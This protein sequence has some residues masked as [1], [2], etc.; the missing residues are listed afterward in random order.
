[1]HSRSPS[2]GA[3]FS[4]VR[5]LIIGNMVWG[6][7]SSPAS[8]PSLFHVHHGGSHNT[9]RHARREIPRGLGT[10]SDLSDINPETGLIDPN[11]LRHSTWMLNRMRTNGDLVPH[12]PKP[13]KPKMPSIRFVPHQDSARPSLQFDPISRTLPNTTDVIRVGRYSEKDG[14]SYVVSDARSSAPVGFKSKVVS[15]KHCEFWFQ[16]GQWYIKDVKSSSGTFLNRLRLSPASTESRPYQVNDGDIIQ[17][18][19]DFKGGEE[20][21]FR[22][23]K[24]RIECNRDW[25]KSVNPYKYVLP[26]TIQGDLQRTDLKLNPAYVPFD[27][28]RIFR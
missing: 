24:M 2:S 18:G 5:I 26:R 28:C 22:C 1:M 14:Q 23:V 13:A 7:E 8:V 20:M 27:A 15:R 9:S 21:I 12:T 3:S 10:G 16:N 17:L 11:S 25:Q 4:T 6:R 19:I